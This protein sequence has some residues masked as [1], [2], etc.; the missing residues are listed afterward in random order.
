MAAMAMASA[1]FIVDC[2]VFEGNLE[3]KKHTDLIA[4]RFLL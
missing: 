4:D 1:I 2:A 3:S